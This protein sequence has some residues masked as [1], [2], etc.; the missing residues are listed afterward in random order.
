MSC[1]NHLTPMHR[2]AC[3]VCNPQDMSRYSNYYEGSWEPRA[4]APLGP[5]VRPCPFCGS[6]V[7]ELSRMRNYVHC[8][9]CGADGP[10]T[11]DLKHP[12]LMQISICKWNNRRT[13]QP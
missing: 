7:L 3:P 2:A 13:Q 6:P 9:G 5:L 4:H 12:N 11:S 1:P 8:V 10:E